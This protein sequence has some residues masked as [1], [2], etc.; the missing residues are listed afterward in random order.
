MHRAACIL[1]KLVFSFKIFRPSPGIMPPIAD[2]LLRSEPLQAGLPR[3]PYGPGHMDDW[4]RRD[5]KKHC[6][7]LRDPKGVVSRSLV[8]IESDHGICCG[9][10]GTKRTSRGYENTFDLTPAE[11]RL[12]VHLVAGASLRSCAKALGIKYET[13]RSCL[14]SVFRKT[15]THRQAELVLTVFEVMSDSN[16]PAVSDSPPPMLTL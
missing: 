11:A 2:Q 14:K 7:C 4:R 12:V 6:W 15:G 5:A 8:R 10:P 1:D 3:R 9:G 16:F 13:V